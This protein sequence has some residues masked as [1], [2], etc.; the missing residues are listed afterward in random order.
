MNIKGV[1]TITST[2]NTRCEQWME[3]CHG[4]YSYLRG[5]KGR[6]TDDHIVRKKKKCDEFPDVCVIANMSLEE[7]YGNMIHMLTEGTKFSFEKGE[8][9]LMSKL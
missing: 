6:V 1:L 3:P 4:K 5:Y 7:C 9:H 2:F 8:I